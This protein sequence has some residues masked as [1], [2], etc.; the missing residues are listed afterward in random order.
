M[1]KHEH[2]CKPCVK[3]VLKWGVVL[4][5]LHFVIHGI[6]YIFNPLLGLLSLGLF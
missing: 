3:S 2:W 1:S 4:Y 6:I 5:L